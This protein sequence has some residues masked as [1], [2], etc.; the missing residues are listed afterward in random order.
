L[1]GS[2]FNSVLI[3]KSSAIGG[4]SENETNGSP[5]NKIRCPT[6]ESRRAARIIRRE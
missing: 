1:G 2:T 6:T 5:K 3:I 4:G